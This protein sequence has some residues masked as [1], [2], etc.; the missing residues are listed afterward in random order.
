MPGARP[1]DAE[2]ALGWVAVGGIAGNVERLGP[3]GGGGLEFGIGGDLALIGHVSTWG[4]TN[5]PSGSIAALGLRAQLA[6]T[7]SV[8]LAAVLGVAYTQRTRLHGV[9]GLALEV[10][11]REKKKVLFDL[12]LM[13][14]SMSVHL[15]RMRWGDRDPSHREVL[16][17]VFAPVDGPGRWSQGLILPLGTI[18]LS[19][20]VLTRTDASNRLRF[21]YPELVAWHHE[22]DA[23]FFDIGG[24]LLGSTIGPHA[25]IG[26][27]LGR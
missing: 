7:R 14:W 8:R 22:D 17:G 10:G 26:V 19:I 21:G 2:R 25:K 4:V 1:L 13:P 16:D 9:P 12:T 20:P 5:G 23:L 24:V 18:G 27:F 6:D 15:G 3:A 11:D